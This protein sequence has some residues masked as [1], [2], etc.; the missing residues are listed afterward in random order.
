MVYWS[1][2]HERTVHRAKLDGTQHEVFLNYNH[3]LGIVDGTD[4][5]PVRLKSR[6][7]RTFGLRM[8][9]VQVVPESERCVQNSHFFD[10]VKHPKTPPKPSTEFQL[11]SLWSASEL[12]P[13][14]T[15]EKSF[16]LTCSRGVD[17]SQKK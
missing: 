9:S 7:F 6:M 12:V 15:D 16:A 14:R 2:V 1:D 4:L 10:D 8:C 11:G 17:V 5:S 13:T 3:S